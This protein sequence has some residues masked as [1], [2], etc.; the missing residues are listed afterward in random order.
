MQPDDITIW[1][2]HICYPGGEPFRDEWFYVVPF[3]VA[4]PAPKGYFLYYDFGFVY[5]LN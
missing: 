4:I 1:D 3:R 2:E 5:I